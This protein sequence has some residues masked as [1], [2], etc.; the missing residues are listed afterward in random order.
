MS[1]L[2]RAARVGARAEGDRP[3]SED[4]IMVGT[5]KLEV[6]RPAQPEAT[7]A[8]VT[9]YGP[10]SAA[11]ARYQRSLWQRFFTQLQ[12]VEFFDQ[13]MLFAAGLLVSLVPFFILVS[14]FA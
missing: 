11:H 2:R 14:A 3:V 12:E 4:A 1:R 9:K 5:D 7:P 10:L 8:P 13:T 6:E